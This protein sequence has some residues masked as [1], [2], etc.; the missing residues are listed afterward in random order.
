MEYGDCNPFVVGPN[1]HTWTI[2]IGN[3]VIGEPK[4]LILSIGEDGWVRTS[5]YVFVFVFELELVCIPDRNWIE[6]SIRVNVLA[7]YIFYSLTELAQT[8]FIFA[9]NCWITLASRPNQPTSQPA[10]V[11]VSEWE[12]LTRRV[13]FRW[14]KHLLFYWSGFVR[15]NNFGEIVYIVDIDRQ[16]MARVV[17]CWLWNEYYNFIC[18]KTKYDDDGD[19]ELRTASKRV[20]NPFGNKLNRNLKTIEIDEVEKLLTLAQQNVSACH[21]H[22]CEAKAKQLPKPFYVNRTSGTSGTSAKSM[23]I[24]WLH[25]TSENRFYAAIVEWFV[26]R[27]TPN[28]ST[29]LYS[30]G[31]CKILSESTYRNEIRYKMPGEWWIDFRENLLLFVPLHPPHDVSAIHSCNSHSVLM[32]DVSY[33]AKQPRKL[34]FMSCDRNFTSLRRISRKSLANVTSSFSNGNY[35]ATENEARGGRE[36]ERDRAGDGNLFGWIG[37]FRTLLILSQSF[38]MRNESTD[39]II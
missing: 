26:H 4:S 10:G 16:W 11:W 1:V 38:S 36:R 24:V 8:I 15:A 27:H 28:R 17:C 9:F 29:T 5:V 23:D 20:A 6:W 33:C 25:R 21:V 30:T 34:R 7:W 35:I 13:P 12:R 32:F 19:D 31:E 18:A 37:F 14:H 22:V 39:N 3:D 2:K